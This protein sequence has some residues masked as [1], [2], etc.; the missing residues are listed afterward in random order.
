[1]F[2]WQFVPAVAMAYAGTDIGKEVVQGIAATY[3]IAR[4]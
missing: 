2:T 1:M 3:R 4:K